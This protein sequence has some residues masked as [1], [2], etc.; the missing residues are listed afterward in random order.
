MWNQAMEIKP[1]KLYVYFSQTQYKAFYTNFFQ[2]MGGDF[3]GKGQQ[4]CSKGI[5]LLA[6][7]LTIIHIFR[8]NCL[9]IKF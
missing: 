1:C 5:Y 8:L 4:D 3:S 6:G 7:K 2:T 9:P